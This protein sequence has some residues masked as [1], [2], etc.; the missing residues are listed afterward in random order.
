MKE[1]FNKCLVLLV[2][3]LPVSFLFAQ[4]DYTDKPFRNRSI[5]RIEKPY[6]YD[7]YFLN[8]S[9]YIMKTN[10]N[11]TLHKYTAYF[12]YGR[13]FG[14]SFHYFE[15]GTI[16]RF[17]SFVNGCRYGSYI[18]YHSNGN[19]KVS[20]CYGTCN[21]E[22]P[23]F[24]NDTVLDSLFFKEYGEYVYTIISTCNTEKIG[25]W[26]YFD[27]AGVELRVESYEGFLGF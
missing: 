2:L 18:E 17:E 26:K 16:E 21:H 12:Q 11:D 4:I 10:W 3:Q 6:D 22:E 9:T 27:S 7:T 1:F 5:Q 8:N 15:N 24:T 23:R 13:E 19:M 20:G 14:P 25:T